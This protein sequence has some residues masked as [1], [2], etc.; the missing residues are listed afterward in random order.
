MHTKKT[1]EKGFVDDSVNLIGKVAWSERS[2]NSIGWIRLKVRLSSRLNDVCTFI[3]RVISIFQYRCICTEPAFPLWK[4]YIL[5]RW[6]DTHFQFSKFVN[7]KILIKKLSI[8]LFFRVFPRMKCD[9][10]PLFRTSYILETMKINCPRINN[11]NYLNKKER[12]IDS[13]AE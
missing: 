12:E 11:W 7:S 8:V 13:G 9:R 4:I 2:T 1:R 10:N 5:S 6:I 3:Y